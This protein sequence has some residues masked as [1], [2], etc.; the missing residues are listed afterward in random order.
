MVMTRSDFLSILINGFDGQIFS[1]SASMFKIFLTNDKVA[2]DAYRLNLL[3]AN[4]LI[5]AYMNAW[6]AAPT[7]PDKEVVEGSVTF[8]LG[9]AS[10]NPDDAVLWPQNGGLFGDVKSPGT[11]TDGNP[12]LFNGTSGQLIKE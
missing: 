12:A 7:D 3:R 4:A 9:T 11:V 6:D 5:D 1:G 8:D 10:F 2:G